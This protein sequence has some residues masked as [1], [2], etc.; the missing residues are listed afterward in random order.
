[1]TDEPQ[2]PKVEILARDTFPPDQVAIWDHV[3]ETRKLS[4]MPNLFAMMGHSPG[5]LEAAAAVGEHVRFHCVLDA[6]L[7]ELVICQVAQEVG[8]AYEWCHHIH[9]LPERLRALV[10]TPA[11]EDEP[12][13]VGPA[14]RF[15]RLVASHEPVDDALIETLKASLGEQG[16]VDLT[17]MVGYYLL[18]GSFCTTLKVPLDPSVERV[19]Y[20]G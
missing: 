17:V 6:D 14:M 3:V 18:V 5:A 8:N 13:P 19:P 1:M 15:S 11:I 4:F 16:L 7:R 9:R 12:A 10:G 2:A 20:N